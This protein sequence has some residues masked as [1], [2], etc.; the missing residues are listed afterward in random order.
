MLLAA[1]SSAQMAAIAGMGAAFIIFALVS[2]VLVPH[3]RPEFPAR[4]LIPYVALCGL[5][6]VGMMMVIVFAAREPHEARAGEEKPGQTTP[7]IPTGNATTGKAFFVAQGCG[8]CHTFTPAGSKGTIGP[9]LDHLASDAKKA[10]R[11]TVE[12][13]TFESID[14]PGAY[15]V[16]GF[17]NGIMPPFGQTLSKKQIA[18]LVAYLTQ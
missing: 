1:L 14:N 15:V 2:S 4:A 12:E 17:Q 13:Y 18:D 3:F 8:Q 11:G 9:D 10:N 7:A 5:F 6:F 16:P